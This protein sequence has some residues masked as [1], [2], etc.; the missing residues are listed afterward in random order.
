MRRIVF[1]LVLV[2]AFAAGARAEAP[3]EVYTALTATTPQMAFW[4]AL[5]DGWNE[6]HS[7]EVRF[8]KDLDDLRGVILAGRGDVWVGHLDGLAQAARRGAPVTLLAVTARAEKFQFL[9]L[10]PGIADPRALAARLAATGG[11]LAVAPRGSPAIALLR[12]AEARGFP[13]VAFA[14]MPLQQLGLGLG[15]GDLRHVL[16]PEPLASVLAARFPALKRAGSLA[17]L[18]PRWA[19]DGL[20]MAGIAVRSALI[21]EN[22]A[23]VAD[24]AKRMAAWTERHRADPAAAVAVLPEK[25]RADVGDAVLAASLAHDPLWME[26]AGR[27]KARV[28]E[29]LAILDPGTPPPPAAFFPPGTP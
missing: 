6:G 29:A 17:D 1:V 18:D 28:L 10:D 12:A 19:A 3:L 23:L 4:G 21:A 16:V 11:K 22:P 14:D 9:T 5:R 2:F 15:R 13:P 26:D 27:A 7:T 24:L 8:W 25:T 20:P